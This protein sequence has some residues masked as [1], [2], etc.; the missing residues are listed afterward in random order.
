MRRSPQATLRIRKFHPRFAKLSELEIA[1]TKFTLADAQWVIAREHA[2]EQLDSGFTWACEYGHLNVIRFLLERGF[3]PN[4]NFMKGE[5]GLHWAAY[6]GHEEIVELLLK[7][8]S[9]VNVKDQVH[10]GTPLGWAIYAWNNPA[11]E[12]K[13]ARHHEVV[14]R[15]VRAGALVD[16]EW[17]DN[18]DRGSS[19]GSKLRADSRMM[20]ALNSR[21]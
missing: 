1:D 21:Q 20:A 8:K 18:S 5:T 3:K 7:I 17:I 13:N 2:F 6:G 11:P 9:P 16:W 10:G 15:L 4:S 14:E 19:L 12:F